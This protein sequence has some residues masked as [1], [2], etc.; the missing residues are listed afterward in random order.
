MS[1]GLFRKAALDKMASPERL[2]ELMRVTSPKGWLA[3][4]TIGVVLAG[5]VVWSIVGTIPTRVAGPGIL[6]A[7][8]YY[9]IEADA[10]GT[11]IDLNLEVGEEVVVGQ[12][13]A[14]IDQPSLEE[15]QG[16]ANQ[17]YMQ[18]EQDYRSAQ[19]SHDANAR[20]WDLQ[21]KTLR[22]LDQN[23]QAQIKELELKLSQPAIYPPTRTKAQIMAIENQIASR[24]LT[25]QGLDASK[26]SSLQNLQALRRQVDNARAEW[27]KLREATERSRQV[28]CSVDARVVSI[29]KRPGDKVGR[30]DI[31]ARVLQ[32]HEDGLQALFF[33]ESAQGVEIRPGMIVEVSPTNI[34]KEEFGFLKGEVIERSA[35]TLTTAQVLREVGGTEEK[36]KDILKAGA[37]YKVRAK[38]GRCETPTGYCWSSGKGPP[39]KLVDNQDINVNVITDARAP[40]TYVIPRVRGM[41]GG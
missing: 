34:K 3:V 2:D 33:V 35:E 19:A 40:Y 20:G 16:Q 8:T 32:G 39:G 10:S 22:G 5:V 14:I 6:A 18:L 25:I 9:F 30:N 27:E 26:R 11:L 15:D 21:I 4:L 29:E 41:F 24:N 38:L 7:G 36:V 31:L 13:V 37:V 17:R 1:E 23:D 12:T 28:K